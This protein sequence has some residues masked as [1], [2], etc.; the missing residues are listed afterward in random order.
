LPIVAV[1]LLVVVNRR[2]LLGRW[3]NGW[4]ANLLGAAVVLTAAGL[5]V[6]KLGRTLGMWGG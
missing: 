5:G 3:A 4:M 6:F 2:S 1:F